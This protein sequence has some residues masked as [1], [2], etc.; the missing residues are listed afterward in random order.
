M[1]ELIGTLHEFVRIFT[2]KGRNLSLKDPRIKADFYYMN[3]PFGIAVGVMICGIS[4]IAMIGTYA[5]FAEGYVLAEI[6]ATW[7]Y[8]LIFCINQA[9]CLRTGSA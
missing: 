2:R 3:L 7:M 8:I 5:P 1:A 6:N 4:L 9:R